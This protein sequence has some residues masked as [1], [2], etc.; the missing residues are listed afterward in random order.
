[1]LTALL[2]NVLVGMIIIKTKKK[3]L[4]SILQ[5]IYFAMLLTIQ[6]IINPSFLRL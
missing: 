3:R 2:I 6:G 5:R 4:M 1:M